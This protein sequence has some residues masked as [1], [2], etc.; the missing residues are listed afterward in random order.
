MY[1]AN[2]ASQGHVDG[3]GEQGRSQE[4]KH[5]L[6]GVCQD[7]TGTAVGGRSSS[8]TYNFDWAR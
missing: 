2:D 8:E 4:D 6:D 1:A 7:A 3:G 5:V